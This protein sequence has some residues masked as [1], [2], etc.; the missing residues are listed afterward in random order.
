MLPAM[1]SEDHP[2]YTCNPR[3][4]C[5]LEP[6][7]AMQVD[8]IRFRSANELRE[9]DRRDHGDSRPWTNRQYVFKV[10]A[11]FDTEATDA[12]TQRNH[13]ATNRCAAEL[14]RQ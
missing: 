4:E 6:N 2:P 3:R 11:S 14:F 13:G 7:A 1:L 8:D 9:T 5:S 12:S 10:H